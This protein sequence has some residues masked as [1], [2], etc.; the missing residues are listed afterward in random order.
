MSL[1]GTSK[2]TSCSFPTDWAVFTDVVDR[3]VSAMILTYP[4]AWS[5]QSCVLCV[6]Q[7]ALVMPDEVIGEF[8]KELAE[9]VADGAQGEMG[10][11]YVRD[12]WQG[13]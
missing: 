10:A 6:L 13:G 4:P 2:G 3:A 9:G 12:D 1:G 7:D 8:P 5:G 11:G